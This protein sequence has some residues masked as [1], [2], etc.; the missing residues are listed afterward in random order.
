[1]SGFGQANGGRKDVGVKV[2]YSRIWRRQRFDDKQ[3]EPYQLTHRDHMEVVI[4]VCI[5]TSSSTIFSTAYNTPR[6]ATRSFEADITF[7]VYIKI[8]Y[9]FRYAIELRPTKS[10]LMDQILLPARHAAA[11]P[12]DRALR[13]AWRQ[14]S[15]R[16]LWLL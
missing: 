5:A 4:I 10:S 12:P 15:P 7:S 8:L 2:R 3:C 6:L 13:G 11:S 16:S 1:M 9:V 14:A